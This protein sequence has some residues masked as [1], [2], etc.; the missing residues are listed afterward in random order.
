[1]H[2]TVGDSDHE[3]RGVHADRSHGHLLLQCRSADGAHDHKE[4]IEFFRQLN[5]DQV[6][7]LTL[8]TEGGSPST[9]QRKE[10]NDA[11]RGHEIPLAVVT[12]S[13]LVRGTLTAY[14]WFNRNIRAFW[15]SITDALTYLKVLP[16]P[17]RKFLNEVQS[18]QDRVRSKGILPVRRALPPAMLGTEPPPAPPSHRGVPGAPPSHRGSPSSPP[19][20]GSSPRSARRPPPRTPHAPS[21]RS[22]P[23]PYS[24]GEDTRPR[25]P[26]GVAVGAPPPTA[27]NP[28]LAHGARFRGVRSRSYFSG[29]VLDGT[30]RHSKIVRAGN[31]QATRHR[32]ARSAVCA[33]PPSAARGGEPQLGVGM[34][35]TSLGMRRVNAARH[36]H[37]RQTWRRCRAAR[38][39]SHREAVGPDH[40]TWA[41]LAWC[42]TEAIAAR[43]TTA[44][45]VIVYVEEDVCS[46]PV[47]ASFTTRFAVSITT[48][49]SG[50]PSIH[51]GSPTSGQ[52]EANQ[53]VGAHSGDAVRRE[54]LEAHGAVLEACAHQRAAVRQRRRP[55]ERFSSEPPQ[56]GVLQIRSPAAG[57]AP[58]GEHGI[59]RESR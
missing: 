20:R 1:M 36:G 21:R 30:P 46:E 44:T 18:L 54:A 31:R 10:F 8:L 53:S 24:Y 26:A 5:F 23:N 34:F 16:G 58:H 9:I 49:P 22:K 27:T 50:L 42:S 47:G 37:D 29:M 51:H 25:R 28:N 3:E 48:V 35:I 55:Q 7:V 43:T 11:L 33:S 6:R 13:M 19:P 32:D 12:D 52:G 38:P 59:D 2:L 4:S 40:R 56:I 39:G 41:R 17:A 14:G 15:A 57:Q 45:N